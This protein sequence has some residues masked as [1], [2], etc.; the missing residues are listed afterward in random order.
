MKNEHASTPSPQPPLLTSE[1]G[2]LCNVAAAVVAVF[3]ATL[4]SHQPKLFI[5]SFVLAALG[6]VGSRMKG[7]V[8]AVAFLAASVLLYVAA[9]R[10]KADSDR[11]QQRARELKS[12][13]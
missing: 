4:L 3:G 11:M 12:Q 13:S 7:R 8:V 5:I 10:G 2:A 6:F 9:S 1:F